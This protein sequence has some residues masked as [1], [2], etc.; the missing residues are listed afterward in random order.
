VK[1]KSLVRSSS[2][3]MLLLL[4]CTGAGTAEE[5]LL[6]NGDLREGTLND[7]ADWRA[8]SLRHDPKTFSW[9]QPPGAPGE[10]QITSGKDVM[11]R[12][13]QTVNLAPGWYR[14]SGELRT[15]NIDQGNAQ[16]GVFAGGAIWSLPI[17]MTRSP[18][19]N[20]GILYFKIG[21]PREVPIVCLLVA[22]RGTAHFRRL[23]LT[24]TSAPPREADQ[25][26]LE[27][28]LARF[29]QFTRRTVPQGFKPPT[30]SRWTVPATIL[31][32][33]AITLLGW[34]GFKRGETD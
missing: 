2:I 1:L 34:F 32:L 16:I 11:A 15:E 27:T 19:W 6:H 22:P 29:E 3:L 4:L 20:S 31:M 12:W 8:E 14:L 26:D 5:N 7:P 28:K 25:V 10:L 21:I 24:T 23:L 30:G 9:S 13:S 17:K 33:V 18:D